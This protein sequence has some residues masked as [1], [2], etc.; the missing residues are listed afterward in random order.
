MDIGLFTC[1]GNVMHHHEEISLISR[2]TELDPPPQPEDFLYPSIKM[3]SPFEEYNLENMIKCPLC[4]NKLITH[5][6]YWTDGVH[7]YQPRILHSFDHLV[8]LVSRVYQCIISKQTLLAHDERLLQTLAKSINVPFVLLHKTGFT[9]EFINKVVA[10]CNNGLNFF[11]IESMS[12]EEHWN[13]H[14]NLE[15][16]FWQKLKEYKSRHP[17]EDLQT[18]SFPTFTIDGGQLYSIPSNDA[19]AQCFLKDFME[20]E[21]NYILEMVRLTSHI[22]ISCDHTFKVASNIGYLREDKKWI[23]QYS[24]VF[25]VLNNDG[26]V[27]SWQFTTG[28]SFAEI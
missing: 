27:I 7:S 22:W 20:K 1:I 6:K 24:T 16:K 17:M 2:R 13:Y 11:K 26:K 12:I 3:W 19:I 23:R 5:G 18:N 9:K 28:T 25:F 21:R 10:L 4:Q 14:S 15:Q 8:L